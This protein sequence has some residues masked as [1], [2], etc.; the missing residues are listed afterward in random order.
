MV[1]VHP[2][3]GNEHHH[4]CHLTMD[5][6]QTSMWVG[7]QHPDW[8]GGAHWVIIALPGFFDIGS[9]VCALT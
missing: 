1:I 2:S 5:I 8:G 9:R 7:V 4:W 6:S 3:S